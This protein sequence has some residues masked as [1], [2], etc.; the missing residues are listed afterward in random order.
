MTVTGPRL[1]QR[2]PAHAEQP[3]KWTVSAANDQITSL[4]LNEVERKLDNLAL[5]VE[6]S[7][8]KL[9]LVS[10]KVND[11]EGHVLELKVK[12]DVPLN[13]DKIQ[14]QILMLVLLSNVIDWTGLRKPRHWH[15]LTPETLSNMKNSELLDIRAKILRGDGYEPVANS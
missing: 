1:R 6:Q 7:T 3:Q 14:D 10:A 15:V 2:G 13:R 5:K 8:N 12:W 11:I 9:D 4:E